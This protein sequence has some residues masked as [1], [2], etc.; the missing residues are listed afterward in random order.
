[1]IRSARNP[2]PLPTLLLCALLVGAHCAAA[3]HAFEHDFGIAQGKVCST[4]IA[5][6]HLGAAAVDTT[7]PERLEPTAVFPGPSAIT[8]FRSRPVP[9]ARQRGPPAPLRFS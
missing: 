6:A 7:I 2:G 4:C 8:A 9:A 5:A 3:L 1:M